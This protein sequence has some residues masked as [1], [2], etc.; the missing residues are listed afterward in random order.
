MTLRTVDDVNR[1][2]SDDLIWRKKELTALRFLIEGSASKIDTRALFLRSGVALLYAHWEGY[3]RAASRIYLEFL[4]FQRLRYEELAP[5][6][7]ALSLRGRLRSASESTRIRLY[8]DVTNL[9]RSGLGERCMIPED[10][11]TTRSNLSSRVLREITESLGLDYRPYE[12]KGHLI[13]ERLVGARNTVAHG[14]Y[15]RLDLDDVLELHSEVLEMLE[16]FRNQIDNA[17]ST[18]SFLIGNLLART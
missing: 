14:E 7:L 15:L 5:N 1:A 17:V 18:G 12:T 10:A 6:I 3:V 16:L 9:F 8:L 13:D 4:R 2:L 11:I